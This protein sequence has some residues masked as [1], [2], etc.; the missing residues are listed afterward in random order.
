METVHT[1]IQNLS[2]KCVNACIYLVKIPFFPM[3]CNLFRRTPASFSVMNDMLLAD[4]RFSFWNDQ[5]RC[6]VNDLH[7]INLMAT[8]ESILDI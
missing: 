4:F 2:S 3:F 5:V 7:G 8:Y 6:L 1:K